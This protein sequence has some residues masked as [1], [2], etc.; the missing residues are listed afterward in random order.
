MEV[1]EKCMKVKI[2]KA[3]PNEWVQNTKK[4][5]KAHTAQNGKEKK[6]TH[7]LRFSK[8]LD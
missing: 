1:K 7:S 4:P 5:K 6:D 8:R 3:Q 2:Y